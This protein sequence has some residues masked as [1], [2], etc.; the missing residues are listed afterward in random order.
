LS[1]IVADQP[2]ARPAVISKISGQIAPRDTGIA[3]DDPPVLHNHVHFRGEMPL[4]I[5]INV[6]FQ[7]TP[8]GATG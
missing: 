3:I 4:S 8:T 5:T 1:I 7:L 6:V 2:V